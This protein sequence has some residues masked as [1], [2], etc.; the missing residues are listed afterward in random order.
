LLGEDL[1][2]L[3]SESDAESSL[4]FD[5]VR[6]LYERFGDH[7]IVRYLLDTYLDTS[8]P[9]TSFVSTAPLGSLVT[10]ASQAW[11]K[12]GWIEALSVQVPERTGKELVE[13]VPSIQSWD[14]TK[15]TFLQSLIW[16]DLTKITE[17]TK[18]YLKD[19][20]SEGDRTEAVYELLLTIA[21]EPEHPL[22]AKFLHQH[23]MRLDMP[24]RDEVWS[25][26]LA[27]H[28]EERGATDRLVEWGWD[29]EKS[30]IADE[31]I[32]LCAI[33]LAWFLT[34]SHRYVRD[35]ATK[36][37]VA[38]LHPRPLILIQVI[39]QFLEV[40][41]PYVAE[42]LYA[43]AYGVA[44]ISNAHEA[45]GALAGKVYEWVFADANP[46]AH[47]LL[48]DYARGV[49]ET[50]HQRGVLP[51]SVEIERVRPPYQTEWLTDIP[52]KEELEHYG[53]TSEDMDDREWSRYSIYHSVMG[54]GDSP[55][56]SLVQIGDIFH[57]LPAG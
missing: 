31:A 21:A 27:D 47:L 48:R 25:I 50:A 19:V 7:L 32:E 52:T 41:D 34:T 55:G 40:N 24:D 14:I 49:V 45:I 29:A 30:H 36:A 44:M 6:F 8:N 10:D 51:P 38:M 15:R 12:S 22:N 9:A 26:Y 46:P 2:Y 1:V 17:A 4:Q 23:L 35:R 42:R 39:E 16:R 54:F 5:V 43:V 53:E 37:L 33:A 57:G 3:P 28:Y 13:L 20:Y 56:I 18:A 11:S